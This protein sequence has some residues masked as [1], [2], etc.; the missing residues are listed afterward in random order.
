[1]NRIFFI[2]LIC[3]LSL[4]N[5]FAQETFPINGVEDN[6]EN[7]YA[8]FNANIVVD[9]NTTV[10]NG[11]LIIKNGKIIS[12]GKDINIPNGVRKFDLNGNFIYPSFIDL[13]SDYGIVKNKSNRSSGGRMSSYTNPQILSNKDGPFSWNESIRPE[14]NSVENIKFDQKKSNILRK[15]GF[16][17]VVSHNMDGIMRGTGTFISLSN[18]V[19]QNIIFSEKASNHFSFMKG[20]SRQRYPSSLM[21]A[22][23]LMKQSFFDAEWYKANSG[24]LSQTNLSL[25]S[26]NDN[27]G[28]PKIIEVSDKLRVLLAQKIEKE[29][30][31]KFLIKGQ[32]D[33]YQRINEIKEGNSNLI[34]PINYPKPFNVDDP[35][36]NEDILLSQLK[37]WE[38]A[39]SNP[40]FLEK[41]G[42]NF[43]ITSHGIKNLSDFRKNLIKSHERGASKS[44]L[45]KALTYNP[46]KFINMDHKIGAIKESFIANF[47]IS[48][49]DIFSKETKILSNWIQG[50][51]HRVTDTNI[52]DYVGN[53]SLIF[54][55]KDD[56]KIASLILN[57]KGNKDK[58]S[59]SILSSSKSDSISIKTKIIVDDEN[60]YISFNIPKGKKG[61]TSGEYKLS[62][63]FSNG[64]FLGKGTL[65]N[66]DW[67]DW[68]ATKNDSQ[69]INENINKKQT[70]KKDIV[71]GK[72]IYPFVEYGTETLKK[73][74][75]IL[76]KGAKLWTLEGKGVIEKG[77]VLIEN[78]KII[79]V[80][81]EISTNE[82]N[83][84]IID[85]NGMHLTP[86]II[87]E[88]SH[89]AL[90]GVNEGSQSNTAEVRIKD[91]VNSEDVNIYR[92]LAG[93][94]TTSQLLHGSA[95]A[96]GGQSAIVKFRWG[97]SPE[98][99]IIKEADEYIK[100]ALGENV[101][102]SRASSSTRF[103]DTRM[104]VEQVFVDAFNKARIYE[105]KW[106]KYNS[107]T[108]K[109]KLSAII[110]RKDIELEALSQILNGKM[111][112]TC[113]SYVQ[114]EINMLM[115]VAEKFNFKVNTF[116]H[117][118]EG[119]KVADIMAR[120]GA[121]AGSF[122]DWWA[123]KNEVKE[124]IPYNAALMLQAG[125]VTSI[126]SDS[127]EMARRLNQEAGKSIKYGNI[128]EVEAMKL[129]T[130]NPAKLLNLD[131]R[132][133]SIKV[134]KDADLVLWNEHPL[135]I[136]SK[137]LKTIVDGKIYFD[138]EE[139]EILREEI[140][141]ERA[142]IISKMK[143]SNT[144]MGGRRKPIKTAHF[145]LHCED[146]Y[147]YQST[148][149]N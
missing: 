73:Q 3:F 103:P 40:Y 70:T 90:F 79:E 44:T 9:Y 129:V 8:F 123:Y 76:I 32:G 149:E 38:M 22:V 53:Y 130:L 112:I 78:G 99:M 1:M 143:N 46:S 56:K 55:T 131:H 75:K 18:D 136:Y 58:P 68:V 133:G 36:K 37:H 132:M 34:I 31:V 77:D 141:R 42:I 138:I 39:P 7:Y 97:S 145:E 122:S 91:V 5:L 102:R 119:Y 66:F 127:R 15:E 86:G 64:R 81:E 134:G 88:H 2:I 13:Y 146:E 108:K 17:S 27:K 89:I 121:G 113:H 105:N 19:E 49:G 25:S 50:K 33:E 85:G 35:F 30:G 109:E 120:H 135:S 26:I 107:L 111:H 10:E 4:E 61:I 142:R 128:S 95:N 104:G 106:K 140:K 11:T 63:Y 20:S 110:P 82:K 137:P 29:V 41:N 87:D 118:L 117:I 45:L 47:F 93:G 16:G 114:S 14:Y 6:R 144:P 24:K 83:I 115:K 12:V 65:N 80:G 59:A 60:V 23:A 98:E 67:I 126:N 116:T 72:V 96:I 54:E 52:N 124:A 94:V 74:Q 100:F 84:K 92:Q 148:S 21:G 71:I 147:D 125:V 101:K 43:S 57:V 28:L 62:G 69:L 139:D 48:D 51:W